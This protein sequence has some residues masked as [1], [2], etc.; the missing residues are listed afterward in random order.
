V[1]RSTLDPDEQFDQR[2]E[3]AR[4]LLESWGRWVMQRIDGGSGYGPSVLSNL[5][6]AGRSA[7]FYQAPVNEVLCSQVDAVVRALGTPT[8]EWAVAHFGRGFSYAFIARG[9]KVAPA[10]V[11]RRIDEL[12]LAVVRMELPGARR[13][14]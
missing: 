12:L 6:R 1:R 3:R 9:S 13:Q 11:S 2:L 10:T 4:H 7:D 8:R 14:T 5:Q